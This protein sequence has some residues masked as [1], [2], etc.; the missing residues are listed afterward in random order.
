MS[1]LKCVLNSSVFQQYSQL[2]SVCSVTSVSHLPAHKQE[3]THFLVSLLTL[4][5]QDRELHKEAVL[6]PPVCC[7]VRQLPHYRSKL[8]KMT[9]TLRA[10]FNAVRFDTSVT[11]KP[12][13]DKVKHV[14]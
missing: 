2:Y 5:N 3:K 7:Y 1:L 4:S 13:N 8:A 9:T 11:S 14:A 12:G 10:A 6:S